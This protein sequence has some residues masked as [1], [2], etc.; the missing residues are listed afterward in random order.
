[1]K[2]TISELIQ[3]AKNPIEK[4]ISKL[5]YIKQFILDNQ[6]KSGDYPIPS[7][8]IY[9]KYVNWCKYN[10]I[11]VKHFTTFFK[12]FKKYFD[13]KTHK[14]HVHYLLSPEG[15]DLSVQHWQEV[16]EKYHD[17]Q[18]YTRKLRNASKTKN[19][20]TKSIKEKC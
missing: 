19:T 4:K 1:M 5:S 9:N 13:T 3:L 8:I 12:D 2:K 14:N 17:G 7:L 11:V 15:F 16:K 20:Q 6:I 10:N 18:F